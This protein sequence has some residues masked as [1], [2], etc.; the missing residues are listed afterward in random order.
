MKL[1]PW[2]CL[3]PSAFCLL[4]GWDGTPA[5]DLSEM[6]SYFGFGPGSHPLFSISQWLQSRKMH[7]FASLISLFLESVLGVGD[8]DPFV[9]PGNQASKP[10]QVVEGQGD[11]QDG[12]VLP[13]LD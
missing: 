10:L 13:I 8:L 9:L 6:G 7:C 12:F 5:G 1:L 2:G 4:A 11:I 3:V